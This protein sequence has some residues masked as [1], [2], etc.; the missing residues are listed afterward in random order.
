MATFVVAGFV[1]AEVV[2]GVVAVEVVTGAVTVEVVA[3]AV[4]AEVSNEE[5]PTPN[6]R[7]I[8]D[9]VIVVNAC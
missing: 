6:S 3:G 8:D 9:I 1:V 7:S 5:L 2:A 4:A